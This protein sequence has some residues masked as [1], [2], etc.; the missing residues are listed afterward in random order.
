MGEA[1]E[2]NGPGQLSHQIAISESGG[3]IVIHE[4]FEDGNS[5]AFHL[6]E[7]AT[8]GPFIFSG[9]VPEELRAAAFQ[10][11]MGA[12]FTGDRDSFERE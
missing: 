5:L 7:F 1:I 10:I 3:Q 4:V 8:P 12:I 11:D 6:S 9:D 2:A